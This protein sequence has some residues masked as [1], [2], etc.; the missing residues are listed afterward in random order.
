MKIL[1]VCLGNICRS[2][3][4]EGILN[5]KVIQAGLQWKIDSAGTSN[6][7][8]GEPPHILSQKVALENRI[9]IGKQKSRQLTAKD[10]IEFDKIYVM[11]SNNYN[12]AKKIA[13]KLWNEDKINLILNT[14]YPNQNKAVPDPWG[15]KETAYHEVFH[16]LDSAC[17]AIIEQ[18]ATHEW[19]QKSK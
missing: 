16:L 5:H 14:I 8:I 10:F 11:D 15:E 7:H 13:G 19:L 4:A 6:Y 12:D 1:M 3:L 2:P 18:Y 17:K 9:D